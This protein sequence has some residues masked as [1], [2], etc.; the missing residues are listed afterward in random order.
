MEA[1]GKVVS[2]QI[3]VHVTFEGLRGNLALSDN[4]VMSNSPFFHKQIQ[5]NLEGESGS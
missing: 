5:G 2:V 4:D 1:C 3:S